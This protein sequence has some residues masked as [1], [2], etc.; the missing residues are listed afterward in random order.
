MLHRLKK[1]ASRLLARRGHGLRRAWA[2]DDVDFEA[3]LAERGPLPA[4]L[5]SI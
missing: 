5:Y 2:S 4:N 1:K 3:F